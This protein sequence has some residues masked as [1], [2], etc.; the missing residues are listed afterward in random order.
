VGDSATLGHAEI[1]VRTM[2]GGAIT[3]VGIRLG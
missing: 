1:S 2:D 3:H